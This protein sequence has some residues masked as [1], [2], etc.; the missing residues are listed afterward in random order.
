MLDVA[1]AIAT[2]LWFWVFIFI[3]LIM[4]NIT[5]VELWDMD[6]AWSA[7]WRAQLWFVYLPW[8]AYA[9]RI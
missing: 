6:H 3:H 5:A 4:S 9:K 7:Y 8:R 2:S 1:Y